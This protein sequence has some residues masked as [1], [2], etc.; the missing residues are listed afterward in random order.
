VSASKRNGR[1]AKISYVNTSPTTLNTNE[2]TP[3]FRPGSAPVI[4]GDVGLNGTVVAVD[5]RGVITLKRDGYYRLVF[6]SKGTPSAGNVRYAIESNLPKPV[7][8][9]SSAHITA[10]VEYGEGCA[11]HSFSGSNEL[12]LGLAIVYVKVAGIGTTS[13]VAIVCDATDQTRGPG[14]ITFQSDLLTPALESV[15]ITWIDTVDGLALAD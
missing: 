15:A 7:V 4:S 1:Q 2:L 14:M 10:N 9:K 13:E 6:D 5:T 3:I 12:N 11:L 8:L